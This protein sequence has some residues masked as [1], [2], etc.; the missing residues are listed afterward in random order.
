MAYQTGVPTDEID[1]LQ[2]LVAFLVG[3]GWTSDHSASEGFGWRAHV[4]KSGLYVN[5]RAMHGDTSGSTVWPSFAAGT[6]NGLGFNLGTGYNGSN[7]W[8]DQAGVPTFFQSSTTYPTGITGLNTSNFSLSPPWSMA[9][10]VRY[11]F[12]SDAADNIVIALERSPLNF[13]VCGWGPSLNK[14][15]GGSWTGGAYFFG[16]SGPVTGE[17]QQTNTAGCP[18][19]CYGFTNADANG[20]VRADVDSY[21]GAWLANVGQGFEAAFGKVCTSGIDQSDTPPVDIPALRFLVQRSYSNFNAQANLIPID[22]YA[23]RDGGGYSLLGSVPGVF[24]TNA[25]TYGNF[26]SGTIY[27]IGADNYMV[28]AGKVLSGQAIPGFAVKQ[29]P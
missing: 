12:F 7:Q 10:F 22:L 21:T 3:L 18:F 20:F 2:Q 8:Y 17:Q 5:L 24:V 9:P 11:H 15:G 13:G 4:H 25:A 26:T 27:T 19:S 23:H 6:F 29:I 16:S 1:L 28:F 14:T